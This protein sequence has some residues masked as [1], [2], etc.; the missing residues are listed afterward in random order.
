MNLLMINRPAMTSKCG[1][2]KKSVRIPVGPHFYLEGPREPVCL[3]CDPE[4]D[5]ELFAVI[6]R[7]NIPDTSESRQADEEVM[8][9]ESAADIVKTS[10]DRG[11]NLAIAHHDVHPKHYGTF[12]NRFLTVTADTDNFIT[13]LPT[14]SN[15]NP[16]ISLECDPTEGR[17]ACG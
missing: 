7:D 11:V 13:G 15:L 10:F 1:I 4:H 17:S 2:C 12:L 5:P 6:H 3:S 8:T 16:G 14:T 9:L